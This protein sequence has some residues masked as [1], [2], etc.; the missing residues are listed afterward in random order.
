MIRWIFIAFLMLGPCLAGCA[1]HYTYLSY[2]VIRVPEELRV[3]DEIR[4]VPKA[5][6]RIQGTLVRI[7]ASRLTIAADG[8]EERTV[9]WEEIRVLERVRDTRITVY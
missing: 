7:E 9:A 1:R 3:G 6:D 5:G 8:S 4:I 2:K